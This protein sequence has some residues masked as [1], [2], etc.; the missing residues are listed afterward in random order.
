MADLVR[1]GQ[2]DM[3]LAPMVHVADAFTLGKRRQVAAFEW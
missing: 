1:K 2:S 3:D